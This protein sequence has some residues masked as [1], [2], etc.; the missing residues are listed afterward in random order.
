METGVKD[1]QDTTALTRLTRLAM[2]I[3]TEKDK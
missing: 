2:E 1:D 3:N